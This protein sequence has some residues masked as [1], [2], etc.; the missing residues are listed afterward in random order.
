M[1]SWLGSLARLPALSGTG[2][3]TEAVVGPDLRGSLSG[4]QVQA[5]DVT[6][7]PGEADSQRPV[8]SAHGGRDSALGGTQATPWVCIWFSWW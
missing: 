2:T 3:P 8:L 1:E 4:L 7:I 5:C 6:V